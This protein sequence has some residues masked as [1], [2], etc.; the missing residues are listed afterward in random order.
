MGIGERVPSIDDEMK[1]ATSPQ[2]SAWLGL[3]LFCS[4]AV[5]LIYEVLWFRQFSSL[6]GSA[7][8]ASA[9]V[10]IAFF[11]GLGLGSFAVGRLVRRWSDLLLVYAILEICVGL[12]ALLVTPLFTAFSGSYARIALAGS[13]QTVLITKGILGFA[14]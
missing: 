12:G 2:N 5:A 13:E 9:A 3:L 1:S 4:G 6:F 14:A 7:A 10:L 11:A 8:S